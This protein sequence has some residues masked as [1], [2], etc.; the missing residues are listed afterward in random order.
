MQYYKIKLDT[1]DGPIVSSLT[2]LFNELNDLLLEGEKEITIQ[3]K[4]MTKEEYE[5]LPEFEGY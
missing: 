3:V 5:Q 4:E 2:E 1:F